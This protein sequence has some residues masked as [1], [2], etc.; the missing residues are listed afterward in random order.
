M[1][2]LEAP[3]SG[4]STNP[5]RSLG[6]SVISGVWSDWWIYFAGPLI[7][8]WIG[9]ALHQFSWLK[10]FEVEIAKIHHFKLDRYGIFKPDLLA[11][12]RQPGPDDSITGH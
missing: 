5:A 6:P 11:E 4:T 12:K 3:V 7:G 1:V 2:Y 10:R 9:L 8:M